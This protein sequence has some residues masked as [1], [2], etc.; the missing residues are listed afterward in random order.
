MRARDLRLPSPCT[1]GAGRTPTD[2]SGGQ[3]FRCGAPGLAGRPRKGP[4]R[5]HGLPRTSGEG[6][7]P[8]T[9]VR[10][11]RARRHPGRAAFSTG[12]VWWCPVRCGLTPGVHRWRTGAAAIAT[13]GARHR[14]RSGDALPDRKSP[15]RG[16]T[17]E[18]GR[19]RSVQGASESLVVAPWGWR[20]PAR[21][22]S[23][24]ARWLS[25]QQG[26]MA[27]GPLRVVRPLEIPGRGGN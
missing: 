10:R 3:G 22:W 26:E 25:Q 19:P 5:P 13:A 24:P 20:G 9:R 27:W 7:A 1:T 4:T 12:H 14:C 23:S 18:K 17:G 11:R 8:V 15:F 21:S 6:T 2:G 16:F